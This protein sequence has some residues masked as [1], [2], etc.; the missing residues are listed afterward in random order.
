M[1][2]LLTVLKSVAPLAAD[3]IYAN[4]TVSTFNLFAHSLQT[5]RYSRMLAEAANIKSSETGKIYLGALFHDVGKIA[6][7]CAILEKPGRL[8][9]AETH[10]MHQHP[11]VA[12]R[13]LSLDPASKVFARYA[14]LHHERIDGHGYPYC[15]REDEIPIGVRIISIVD[16]FEAMISDR[17]YRPALGIESALSELRLMSGLQFDPELVSLWEKVV[18][19][20][21]LGEFPNSAYLRFTPRLVAG[22]AL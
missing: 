9:L 8:D 1:K 10:E 13:I 18:A 5:A 14:G 15:L 22:A 21:A 17:S 16:A 12:E 11:E 2:N 3:H 7:D 6:V 4:Y 19:R 20:S